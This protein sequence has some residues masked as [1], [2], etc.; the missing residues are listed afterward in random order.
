MLQREATTILEVGEGVLDATI[1]GDLY[2]GH[3]DHHRC[4]HQVHHCVGGVV[5]KGEKVSDVV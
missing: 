3:R 5:R 4:G 1:N 2:Q